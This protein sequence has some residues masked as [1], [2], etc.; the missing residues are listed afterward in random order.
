MAFSSPQEGGCHGIEFSLASLTKEAPHLF[1]LPNSDMV[2]LADATIA[3]AG[4]QLPVHSQCLAAASAVLCE[5]F[6]GEA[7]HRV[8]KRVCL[9]STVAATCRHAAPARCGA[10]S[11]CLC[12]GTAGMPARARTELAT[13]WSDYTLEEVTLFLRFTYS[14]QDCTPA[15]L[16]KSAA[17]LPRLLQLAHQLGASRMVDSLV[18]HVANATTSVDLLVRFSNTADACQLD[19]AKQ[20]CMHALARVLKAHANASVVDATALQALPSTALAEL[21]GC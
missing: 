16:H 10:Q 6:R 7:E 5:V 18:Q 9:G 20:K 8:A 19:G 1:Y 13:P 12:H 3:V 4:S 11:E 14:P 21:L 17:H 15:N 2:D